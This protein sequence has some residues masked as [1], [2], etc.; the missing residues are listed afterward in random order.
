MNIMIPIP[1]SKS[2]PEIKEGELFGPC[3]I[4]RYINEKVSPDYSALA[5]AYCDLSG[6]W[7]DAEPH[8]EPYWIDEKTR[9]TAEKLF[10]P[11]GANTVVE[12]YKEVELESLFPDSDK[13]YDC[14]KAAAENKIN[15][16]FLH[17]EGQTFFKNYLIRKINGNGNGNGKNH[18]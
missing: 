16:I 3:V 6:R 7:Q 2:L 13:S 12:W 5:F 14:A 18:T 17:Q 1:V 4:V 8:P 10:F 15:G 11:T 9:I